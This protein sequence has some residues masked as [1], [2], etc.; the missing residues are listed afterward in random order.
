MLKWLQQGVK[1]ELAFDECLVKGPNLASSSFNTL[2]IED[3]I[4][5]RVHFELEIGRVRFWG[6]MSYVGRA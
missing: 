3:V 2:C 1:F 5:F 4:V 6:S